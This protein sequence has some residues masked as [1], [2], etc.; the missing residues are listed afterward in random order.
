MA[1][2]SFT[3]H[4]F[5][6]GE[7]I[8]NAETQAAPAWRW[9]SSDDVPE[10]ER[11]GVLNEAFGGSAFPCKIVPTWRAQAPAPRRHD[12]VTLFRQPGQPV[13]DHVTPYRPESAFLPK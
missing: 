5:A 3:R 4:R 10:R 6:A 13:L 8:L 9:F 2:S 1:R 12:P 7:N 11:L